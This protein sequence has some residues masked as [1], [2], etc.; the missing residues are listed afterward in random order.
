MA[1]QTQ[2][3]LPKPLSQYPDYVIEDALFERRSPPWGYKLVKGEE[4][5]RALVL[6]PNPPPLPTAEEADRKMREAL[7]VGPDHEFPPDQEEPD[8]FAEPEK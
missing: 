2:P 1:V 6:D 3:R 7:G 5:E 8:P 4:G